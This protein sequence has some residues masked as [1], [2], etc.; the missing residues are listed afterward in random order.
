MALAWRLSYGRNAGTLADNPR[1]NKWRPDTG[2]Y[3]NP[4]VGEDA[5]ALTASSGAHELNGR[6]G[7]VGDGLVPSRRASGRVSRMLPT[8]VATRLMPCT[9]SARATGRPTSALGAGRPHANPMTR[10]AASG[11]AP[12]NEPCEER[13]NDPA[14]DENH[15]SVPHK[16]AGRVED[17]GQP[18]DVGS[19]VDTNVHR[20]EKHRPRPV[21]P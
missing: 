17:P 5:T 9:A 7:T 19:R 14:D 16:V 10:G 18:E 4:L 15:C 8:L 20:R 11:G 1:G 12:P 3:D 6:N 21:D 2:V 13:H